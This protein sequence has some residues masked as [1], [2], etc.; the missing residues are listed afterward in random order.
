LFVSLLATFLLAIPISLDVYPELGWWYNDTICMTVLLGLLIVFFG[1][2]LCC[3]LFVFGRLI[4]INP[5][6]TCLSA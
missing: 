2:L 3:H 4:L 5:M 1:A 6:V